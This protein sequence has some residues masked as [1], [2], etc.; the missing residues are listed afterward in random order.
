MLFLLMRRENERHRKPNRQCSPCADFVVGANATRAKFQLQS[1]AALSQ[2][3][4]TVTRVP[5]LRREQP[6]RGRQ[7][8]R[9]RRAE[10]FTVADTAGGGVST[11][12]MR[13]S[14]R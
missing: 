13:S 10:R 12:S 4:R 7:A 9:G 5:A 11:G 1:C 3:D 6:G 14:P 8:K 2:G